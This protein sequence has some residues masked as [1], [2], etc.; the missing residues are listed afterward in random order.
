VTLIG[1]TISHYSIREKLGQGGMGEVYVAFDETLQREVA[2]KAI[3]ADHRLRARARTRF[4]REAQILGRLDH[5]DICRIHDYLSSDEGDFLVLEL[6]DGKPLDQVVAE[7]L[8]RSRAMEVARRI[9]GVLVAAHEKMVVHRDLKPENVMLT[10]GGGVKVLDFGLARS[11]A[12]EQTSQDSEAEAEAAAGSSEELEDEGHDIGSA[13]T[14]L[15]P[16]P[17]EEETPTLSPSVA[18]QTRRGAVIGTLQYMSPEQARGEPATPASD[19]YA[20]GLM[21]Q[22]LFTGES[23]YSGA[24]DG[25]T[26]LEMARQG[27]TTPVTGLDRDLIGLI[28][29]LKSFAPAARPTAVETAERLAWIHD[30]P[31]RRLRYLAAGA[32]ATILLASGMKYTFDLKRERALAVEAR[33]EASQRR[34][35]AEDLIGFMLGDLRTKLEPVGRLDI[36]DDV[37]DKALDYFESVD[38][39]RLT[40]EELFR[41]SQALTQIGQVRMDQGNLDAAARAFRQSLTLARDLVGRDPDN[42]EWLAGQGAA[43]FWVGS[44]LWFQSDLEGAET[45][46]EQYLR[47]AERL[48]EM[49]PQKPEWRLELAYA[50]SN[51]GSVKEAQ[52]DLDAALDRYRSTLAAK[53]ELCALDPDNEDWQLDLAGTYN[54]IGNVLEARGEL[55]EAAG[56]F[57]EE[58]AIKKELVAAEPANAL[59]KEQL[60]VAHNYLGGV[61]EALG[62]LD[63]AMAEYEADLRIAT[64]LVATDPTNTDWQRGLA[65]SHLRV[66]QLLADRGATEA[67]FDHVTIARDTLDK[68]AALD[69]SNTDW[70]RLEGR[71]QWHLGAVLELKEEHAAALRVIREGRK[72]L[73]ALVQADSDD[74]ASRKW[75]GRLLLLEGEVLAAMGR[76][77]DARSSWERAV[78]TI[79]TQARDSRDKELLDPLA[80]ALL[81]LGRTGEAEPIVRELQAL[82]YR[83]PRFLAV[84]RRHGLKV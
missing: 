46:F 39:S 58:L 49:D 25:T 75:L 82:G 76:R 26:L 2:L 43:H 42:Q 84:C 23:P 66:G 45:E 21:L 63:G 10:A 51:I 13:A 18:H 48:V 61:L 68:L 12:G 14:I 6:I 57:R 32:L 38:P 62:D 36:L 35:Q 1:K 70:T 40:G 52:G 30:K 17:P 74:V 29:R 67:A 80:R 59:V 16:A 28:N 41:Q 47:I 11:H 27:R 5:P 79:E 15:P 31:K 20:F 19:M 56:Q 54:S 81:H 24:V 73:E 77:S 8:D 33:D 72:T 60:T 69:P 50:N 44:V 71:S 3:R 7:G 78:E 9:A 37:G 65:V 53:Q 55:E 83:D 22:V 64:D 34:A 4:L